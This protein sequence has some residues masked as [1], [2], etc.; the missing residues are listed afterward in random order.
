MAL[1]AKKAA[2]STG[3]VITA[4]HNPAADNGVKLVEPTGYMLAQSWEVRSIRPRSPFKQHNS[5][6]SQIIVFTPVADNC[7]RGCVG[8]GKLLVSPVLSGM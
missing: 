6:Q 4:S 1:R 7:L 3:M 8:G 2:A 5:S